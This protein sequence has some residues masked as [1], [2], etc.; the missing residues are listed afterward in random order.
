MRGGGG[1]FRRKKEKLGR[2]VSFYFGDLNVVGPHPTAL[3]GLSM[4]NLYQHYH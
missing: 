4:S 1:G 3:P 2:N